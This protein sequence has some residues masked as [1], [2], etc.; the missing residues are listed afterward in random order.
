M[1]VT[2]QAIIGTSHWWEGWEVPHPFLIIYILKNFFSNFLSIELK[3]M[4]FIR[5]MEKFKKYH[6]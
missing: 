6:F 1:E 2:L 4:F 3:N 5:C